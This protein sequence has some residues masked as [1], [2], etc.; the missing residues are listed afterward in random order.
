MLLTSLPRRA[1]GATAHQFCTESATILADHA[2]GPV[3]F[4][5]GE[6]E[7]SEDEAVSSDEDGDDDGAAMSVEEVHPFCS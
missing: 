3:H 5:D 4:C 2:A 6:A 7:Q 1:P